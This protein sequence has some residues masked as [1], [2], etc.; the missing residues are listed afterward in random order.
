MKLGCAGK[1]LGK[2]GLKSYDARRRD[3]NPHLSVSLAYVR[4]ILCYLD[5]VDIRFYRL[6]ARLAPYLSHPDMPEFHE[7]IEECESELAFIG[8]L[9]HKMDMRLSIH[10][11]MHVVLNSTDEGIARQGA[12]TLTALAR[13][14]DALKV[15][16]EAIIVVHAGGVYDDKKAAMLRFAHRY[17]SIPESTRRRLALENDHSRYSLSEVWE[18]SRRCGCPIVFDRLHHLLNNPEGLPM[19]EALQVALDSWPAGI[20]PIIH[21]SSPRTDM[22]YVTHGRG[23]AADHSVRRPLWS[24]HSDYVNPF[25]FIGFMKLLGTVRD[26]GVMIEAKGNDLAVIR[27]REDLKRFSSQIRLWGP[28]SDPCC[29]SGPN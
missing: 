5:G 6:S 21:F 12:N 29:P 2:P 16:P 20:T 7:Q 9:A 19:D 27:L 14:L 15:G 18:L 17:E 11:P 26:F 24:E 10:A 1:I 8:D 13:I 3:N 22:H 25:E 23:A 28:V 4:D